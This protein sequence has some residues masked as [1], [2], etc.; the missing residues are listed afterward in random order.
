MIVPLCISG[1]EQVMPKGSSLLR[2]GLIRMRQLP[3]IPYE[4]YQSLTAFAF[5]NR[6]W[7]IMDRELSTM[8]SKA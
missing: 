4:E 3:A 7:K 8:E 5:K 2:P 1:S 6:V